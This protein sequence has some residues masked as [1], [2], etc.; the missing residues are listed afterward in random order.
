MGIFDLFRSPKERVARRYIE[1]LRELGELRR[2]EYDA[3]EQLVVAF[4]HEGAKE[5]IGYLG[6]L[7][8]EISGAPEAD[9]AAIY[10]RFATG[11]INAS[12]T[13]EKRSFES[14]RSSL[15]ILLKDSTYPSYIALMNEV[16]FPGAKETDLVFESIAA[17]I[18]ACC[19]EETEASLRFIKTDDLEEWGVTSQEAL[20][21]AKRNVCELP[22]EICQGNGRFVFAN[23]SFIAARLTNTNIFADHKAANEWVAVVPDR[24]TFFFVD[25][26]D[27]EGLVGL[28]N[29]AVSQLQKGERTISAVPLVFRDEHWQRFDPPATAREA[30]G[31]AER[32]F[33]AAQWNDYKGALEKKFAV[34]GQDIFVATCNVYE[35]V[36]SDAHF[37][38]AVW[39]KDVDTFLPMVDRVYFYDGFT[40]QTR[41]A[42]WSDVIRIMR[43]CMERENSA[44]LHY[45][46]RAFPNSEQFIAMGAKEST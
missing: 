11:Q 37:S 35:E 43:Q 44:P 2:L 26:G 30:F 36:G 42:M 27:I 38:M 31:N 40:K 10:R 5:Q 32:Q 17:D 22:Y 1:V 39:S 4:N 24:D 9:H 25:S 34:T 12:K 29:L 14:V 19:I 28:A 46:V 13:A 18:I 8:R 16:E 3:K 6:N 20:S 45:R 41:V 7:Q 33:Q 23:D 15:R 21:A